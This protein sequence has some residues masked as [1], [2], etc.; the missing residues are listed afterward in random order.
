MSQIS[1]AVKWFLSILLITV[2]FRFSFSPPF[3]T[4]SVLWSSTSG[5][6]TSV[7]LKYN[8]YLLS[9][10]FSLLA[11]GRGLSS[12]GLGLGVMMPFVLISEITTIKVPCQHLQ[13]D[14]AMFLESFQPHPP[15]P[16][17]RCPW[18]T[19]CR[20]ALASSPP[21]SSSSPSPPS[22]SSSSPQGSLWHSSSSALFFRSLLTF[23]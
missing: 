7:L 8:V 20:S 14:I 22:T 16:G 3:S 1:D 13:T 12:F 15:R 5:E 6:S 18:S 17:H 9:H 4:S 21:T 11:C 23:W 10:A 19:R 2:P